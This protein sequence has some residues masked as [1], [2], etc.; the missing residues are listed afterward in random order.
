MVQADGRTLNIAFPY[1]NRDAWRGGYNYLLNLFS[2]LDSLDNKEIKPILFVGEDA[3]LTALTPFNQIDCAQVVQHKL[4]NGGWKNRLLLKSLVW[5]K[6]HKFDELF[7][8]H[9]IDLIFENA[10]FFG[11]YCTA[12][13]VAW[14]PDFQHKK[15]P[16]MFGI[17]A[18]L[19]REFGF[20][21]QIAAGRNV[22]LS[23][24]DSRRDFE[25]YYP[26]SKIAV[27]VIPFAVELSLDILEISP[28]DV[29]NKYNLPS[30][31][32]YLPNQFWPHKNHTLVLEALKILKTR[33]KSLVIV[34]SGNNNVQPDEFVDMLKLKIK[35]YRL[36]QNFILLGS[37]PYKDVIGLMRA[38]KGV[39]N[40]SLFEGWSTTVEE[41]KALGV[42][43][44]LSNLAVHKEQA[45]ESAVFFK[46]N[47]PE[48][49]VN[50]LTYDSQPSFTIAEKE[51]IALKQAIQRRKI[52]ANE[53]SEM[54]Q[55]C[56]LP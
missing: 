23:S 52:F 10:C 13:S 28:L 31:F 4:F 33:G 16:G 49:L 9:D 12:S 36:D 54:V 55:K 22:L 50:A 39:V 53:F 32:Y 34:A 19:K 43:M 44:I 3:D 38:A 17:W 30:N 24:N 47:S 18:R 15:L 46:R 14:I 48:S 8:N 7:R 11:R 6:H 25:L 27:F 42:H 51:A 40:P 2:A 35:E 5:G 29:R 45:S 1:I 21:C 56:V 37:I 20:R 41:A 26:R